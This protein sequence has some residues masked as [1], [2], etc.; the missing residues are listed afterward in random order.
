MAGGER[1][2]GQGGRTRSER[3]NGKPGAS[4]QR[5]I[6]VINDTKEILDAFRAIL[7]D[8]AYRVSLDNFSAL[9]VGQML[10]NVKA[11]VPDAIILDFLFGG[12]PIGWQFLQLL[13]MDR[14]TAGIP[15]VVCTAAVRQAKEQEAHLRTLGV[16]IVLKPFDIDHVLDALRRALEPEGNPDAPGVPPTP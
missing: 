15:I 1:K 10:A 12:E 5:H 13:K 11:L 8:E 3:A 14:A 6:L 9:D 2:T 16:E 4:E 7:E